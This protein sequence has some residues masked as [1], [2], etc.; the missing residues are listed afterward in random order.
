MSKYGIYCT[1]EKRAGELKSN[2]EISIRFLI[3]GGA[4][5]NGDC[6]TLRRK[7]YFNQR[8]CKAQIGIC[9]FRR[10][11]VN[12]R[13]IDRTYLCGPP[14]AWSS[15]EGRRLSNS[16]YVDAIQSHCHGFDNGRLLKS[17]PPNRLCGNENVDIETNIRN[18]NSGVVEHVH[19]INSV[20]KIRRPN[21]FLK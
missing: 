2:I 5:W 15:G 19:G 7:E 18:D 4:K 11:K 17:S 6:S 21:G 16:S 20:S 8:G 14:I 12:G 10:E 13:N 1:Y 3:V 9:G